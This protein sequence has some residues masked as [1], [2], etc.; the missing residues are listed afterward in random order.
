MPGSDRRTFM[1]R[2]LWGAL[3]TSWSRA[4]SALISPAPTRPGRIGR[5][6]MVYRRLGRTGLDISEISLGGSPL[7]D[8]AVLLQAVERGVNYIDTSHS[9]QNGNS[10][11]AVGR[12]LKQFGRDKLYVHTRFHLRGSWSEQS[13]IRSVEGSLRRLESDY[14]DI[15]GIH[16]ASESAQLTDERVLSAFEKLKQGGKYRFRGLSCHTNHQEVIQAAVACGLYDMVTLGFNVFDIQDAEEEVETYDDYLGSSGIRRLIA[17]AHSKDVG[18]VA[19]KTLKVGG[20]RQNL[21]KY[22]AGDTTLFQAMLKWVLD[23]PH[24]SAAIVEMLTFSQLEE[25]L[26]VVGRPLSTHEKQTLYRFV[27]ENGRNYCHMCGRCRVQC[28]AELPIPDILRLLAYHEGYR[29]TRRAQIAYA[30]LKD[31]QKAPACGD[32]GQCEK[33]CSYRV[34]VRAETKRAH[35]L[36]G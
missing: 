35:A 29:K 17:L 14:V 13:I 10:E 2:A 23:N 36:L 33:A 32:C 34:S 11:R 21:A 1:K 6:G 4:S 24:V 16:G 15:L 5:N 28:P 22:T 20:R 27:A 3:G 31:N 9:Y 12:L 19:M 18:V 7:P 30:A 8:W 26:A 25:D